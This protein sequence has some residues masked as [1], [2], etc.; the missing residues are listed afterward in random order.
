MSHHKAFE[1]P[2]IE[3]EKR[4]YQFKDQGHG[5]KATYTLDLSFL[6]EELRNAGRTGEDVGTILANA[7]EDIATAF[8]RSG[9]VANPEDGGKG[10]LTHDLLQRYDNLMSRINDLIDEAGTSPNEAAST[11]LD[12]IMPQIDRLAHAKEADMR[13]V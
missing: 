10:R 8:Q 2:H 6:G 7:R 13:V 12:E 1:Q 11:F 9:A 4:R 5:N 3:R